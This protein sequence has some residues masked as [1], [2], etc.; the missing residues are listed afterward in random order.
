MGSDF[1]ASLQS[2]SMPS[3]KTVSPYLLRQLDEIAN[4]NGG[5]VPLHG[6][7]FA[8]WMHSA[9]PQECPFPH[10]SGTSNPDHLAAIVDNSS[11]VAE[12]VAEDEEIKRIVKAAAPRSDIILDASAH[13]TSS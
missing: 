8:Q 10:V 1:V 2:L 7:L 5:R 13:E 3:G 11:L 12:A 6:R 4:M 9:Y